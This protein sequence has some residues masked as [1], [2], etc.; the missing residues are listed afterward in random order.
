MSSFVFH[1]S[2]S[3]LLAYCVAA[4]LVWITSLAIYRRF[5]HPLAK[6]PGPFWASITHFYIVK[7]NLFSGRSQFYLQIE[8][9]HQQYGPVVRISPEE[10]H[11]ND[12]E[13]HEKIYYIGSTAPSKAVYFYGSFGMKTAAFATTDNAL[14]RVRRAAIHPVFSRKAVLQLED[15]VQ[16]KAQ[17]L[18]HRMEEFLSQSKP[19]DLHHGYR[20]LAVDVVT[21]YSFDNCYNQLDSPNF[22]VDF[23]NMTGELKPRRWVVQAFPI[24]G[25][26]SN[27]ITPS[28][29][30]RVNT[31]LYQFMQFRTVS[32]CFVL[33]PGG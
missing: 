22:A 15:V 24:M 18:V 19:V 27:L 31:A 28:I 21:D 33:R 3:A 10:I 32:I 29:A 25:P 6:I 20:A 7:Y 23:F 14:H 26:I 1:S 2:F 11:L 17:K 30:K 5:F 16:A 9:L 13:N 12:P 8:K 4:V